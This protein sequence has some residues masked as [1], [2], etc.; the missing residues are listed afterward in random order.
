MAV[1][2]S[3]ITL[4]LSRIQI[5]GS[6]GATS[7]YLH[8][9]SASRKIVI[10]SDVSPIRIGSMIHAAFSVIAATRTLIS[11]DSGRSIRVPLGIVWIGRWEF[12]DIFRDVLR[13]L[14]VSFLFD[15]IEWAS[16]HLLMDIGDVESD[17]TERHEYDSYHDRIDHD[18]DADVGESVVCDSYLV[19]KL[20]E[21]RDKSKEYDEKSHIS[22]QLE[23]ER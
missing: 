1:S 7:P 22:N 20:E 21:E 9:C 2:S 4:R 3:G 16:D 11:P 13:Q 14:E 8:L 6:V 23:W 18:D 12:M 15:D 19:D 5:S 17:E 10:I